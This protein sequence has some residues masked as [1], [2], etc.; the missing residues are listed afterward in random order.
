MLK[1][2]FETTNKERYGMLWYF[3]EWSL[4]IAVMEKREARGGRWE[5]VKDG[6]FP[7]APC[8]RALFFFLP[9]LPTTQ[10]G[11]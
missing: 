11:L 3:L 9:S 1:Q 4:K 5:E 2:N 8:P 10:R 7:F 6:F